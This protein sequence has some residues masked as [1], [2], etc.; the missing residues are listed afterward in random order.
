MNVCTGQLNQSP[1]DRSIYTLS[2]HTSNQLLSPCLTKELWTVCIISNYI[3]LVSLWVSRPIIS[4]IFI[5]LTLFCLCSFLSS[6][7]FNF[8]YQYLSNFFIFILSSSPFIHLLSPSSSYL[9]IFD[10]LIWLLFC[11]VFFSSIIPLSFYLC[12][13]FFPVVLLFLH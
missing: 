7:I 5:S 13:L 8:L 9:S 11:Q 6:I 12:S 3:C 4:I 1:Q 2:L 10:F